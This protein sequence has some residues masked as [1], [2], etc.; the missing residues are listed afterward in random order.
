MVLSVSRLAR[1]PG[2]NQ[3]RAG[4]VFVP[5]EL[6][7]DRV[8]ALQRGHDGMECGDIL[9][10]QLLAVV[11]LHTT[12]LAAPPNDRYIRDRIGGL[13]ALRLAAYALDLRGGLGPPQLVD[14]A[15][16]LRAREQQ[17][18]ARSAVGSRQA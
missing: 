13:I 7:V 1:A 8:R 11:E 10:Q 12:L 16:G 3:P 4:S 15:A 6:R 9:R 18:C 14:R 5:V 2:L 17:I